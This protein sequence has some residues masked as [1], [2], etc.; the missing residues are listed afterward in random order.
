MM[1]LEPIP[2][3]LGPGERLH[4]LVPHDEA[5]FHSNEQRRQMWMLCNE[6]PLQKK[7]NGR[8]VHVSDFCIETTGQLALTEEEILNLS[9]NHTLRVTNACKIIYP[10][11]N[12]DVWWNSTQLL[13]Q[14]R[15]AIDIFEWKHPDA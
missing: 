9:A 5:I 6:Q 4:L 14:M 10:G 2:P 3:T 13:D 7:G 15:D 11:K 12:H 1:T 8:A